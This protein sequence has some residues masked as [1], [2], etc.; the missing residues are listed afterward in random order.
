[1]LHPFLFWKVNFALS[2]PYRPL[3]TLTPDDL[4]KFK[5]LRPN[6]LAGLMLSVDLS[7]W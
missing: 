3:H 1:M 7:D 5:I 6:L 2:C 4:H